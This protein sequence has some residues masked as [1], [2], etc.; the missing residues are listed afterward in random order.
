M[1]WK[2]PLILPYKIVEGRREKEGAKGEGRRTSPLNP[3]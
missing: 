3:K 1:P 2:V